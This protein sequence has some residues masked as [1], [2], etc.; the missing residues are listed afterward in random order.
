VSFLGGSKGEIS[1]GMGVRRAS[2]LLTL[3][4]THNGIE[5]GHPVDVL[6]D[7]GARRTLGLEVRC[8]D[9]ARR[10]LPLGAARLADDATEVGSPLSLL[11]DTAFYRARGAA[12]RDLRG[13]EVTRDRASVGALVDLYLRDDGTI[14]SVAVETSSG[15]VRLA[16]GP[17]VSV[18]DRRRA[19][20][21]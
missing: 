3:P 11:D 1:G 5:L 15:R 7:L 10:F 12:F 13:A 21:A 16:L 20:A 9:E 8:R 4:V 18:G 19:S 17:S 2:E 6:V 14:A